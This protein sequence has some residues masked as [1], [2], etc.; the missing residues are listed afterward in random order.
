[1]IRDAAKGDGVAREEFA[2]RYQP[3]IRAYLSARWRNGA[4][5]DDMDDAVQEV[6]LD[7]FRE[8]GALERADPE[9]GDFRGFLYGIVRNVARRF[10]ERRAIRREQQP[11]SDFFGGIRDADDPLSAVFD[12]AWARALLTEAWETLALRARSSGDAAARRLELLRLRFQE[13]MPI[14]DI[15]EAW[16]ADPAHLHH[17]YARARDEFR[18]ALRE[19]VGRYHPGGPE[20]AAAECVRLLDCL[21]A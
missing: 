17:D 8:H 2:R 21:R 7:C 18:S 13:E 3:V 16:G 9:A 12:R 11:A 5:R 6:F 4:P 14:R 15:A 1:M 19:V 20:A 10:E